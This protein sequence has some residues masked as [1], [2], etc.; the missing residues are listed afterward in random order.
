MEEQA[1]HDDGIHTYIS[2]KFPLF[3]I[4]GIIYAVCGISTDI[5]KRKQ[6]EGELAKHRQH[7]EELVEER[8]NELSEINRQ[9]ILENKERKLA[10][11]QLR[12]LASKLSLTEERERRRI[13]TDLHDYIGQKLAITK[14]KLGSLQ[15][16]L[17]STDYSK[18][19]KEI[20]QLIEESIKYARSLMS[21]LSPPILYELGFEAAIE[22]LTE[23][24][25]K[26]H[27]ISCSFKDD[28]RY[29]PL[30][31]EIRGVLFQGVRELLNNIVKYAQAQNAKVSICKDSNSLRIDVK[32]DGIGFDV[33][34]IYT[35]E[36]VE[37]G[38]G[39]FNIRER[40]NY[41]GGSVKI[42]SKPG[43]GTHVTL[44][45]QLKSE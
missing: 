6:T 9:L 8:T 40:L 21:E 19:L 34:K 37:R 23:Q 28:K 13:A 43:H 11:K 26:Q 4:K 1:P 7:L 16:S 25:S 15:E 10:E 30:A 31:D 35:Y 27:D 17:S 2:V 20:K 33:S 42:K 38:F 36:N 45:A 29:K 24:I 3:D 44:T 39:L 22:W 32:D 18:E 5:T 41:L 14:I 12:S